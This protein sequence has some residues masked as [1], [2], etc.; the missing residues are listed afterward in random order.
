MIVGALN[1]DN[2]QDG[3]GR[4]FVYLGSAAGLS[5]TAAWTGE[6]NQTGARCAW[7]STA[8]DV[9]GDGYSDVMTSGDFFDNPESS[10]GRVLGL[11]GV[12]GRPF[13]HRRLE[14]RRQSGGR[15]LGIR[16]GTAG[17]VNGD[18]Y[19]DVILS[20]FAYDNGQTDEGRAYRLPGR[21][22]RAQHLADLD[23]RDRSGG[24]PRLPVAT[25][26]DVNGD[27]FSDVIFGSYMYDGRRP[28]GAGVPLLRA[29]RWS[30]ERPGLDRRAEPVQRGLRVLGHHRRRRERRRLLGLLVGANGYDNGQSQ[31][32]AAFVYPAGRRALQRRRRR[33]EGNQVDALFG[34]AVAPPA[35]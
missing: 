27:G 15:D 2:D 16:M 7:V 6:S 11:P 4:A 35:T 26:G 22:D 8:G 19:A 5:T 32:G 21:P 33:A 29:A 12:G 28:T 17:D 18:G 25:A 14:H 31:E 30:V 3:E 10:E 34:S 24:R 13:D 1:Y 20:A 9:N 23:G